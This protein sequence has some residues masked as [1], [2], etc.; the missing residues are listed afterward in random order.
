MSA[1]MIAVTDNWNFVAA[2]Y[3]ITV[4]VLGG[5]SLWL[6]QRLRRARRS[7]PENHRD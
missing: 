6:A 3:L 1:T 2:G 4:A 5:Y 7:L